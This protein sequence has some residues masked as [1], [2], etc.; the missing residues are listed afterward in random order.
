MGDDA[1]F[2]Y[3]AEVNWEADDD[4]DKTY[5]NGYVWDEIT[6]AD[7]NSNPDEWDDGVIIH[8]WT[9]QA[10]DNY[11]CDDS[12]GGPHSSSDNAQDIELAFAKAL[13]T[14]TRAP[15]AACGAHGNFYLDGGAWAA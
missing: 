5:Y 9:H 6:V 8:E 1:I 3:Q 13:P 11:G 2:D 12:P 4:D 7:A 15:C 10:D 14:T